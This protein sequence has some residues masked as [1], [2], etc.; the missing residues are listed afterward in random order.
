VPLALLVERV[1]S[2]GRRPLAADRARF[3]Q[4]YETRRAAYRTAHYRL[5]AERNPVPP[6]SN[7]SWTILDA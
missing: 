7:R 5:D 6:W 2:D 4:L 1:P 3:E